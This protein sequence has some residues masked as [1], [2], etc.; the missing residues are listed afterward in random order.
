MELAY[1]SITHVMDILAKRLKGLTSVE[2]IGR[3]QLFSSVVYNIHT[4]LMKRFQSKCYFLAICFPLS[5]PLQVWFCLIWYSLKK[6]KK[7]NIYIDCLLELRIDAGVLEFCRSYSQSNVECVLT[8]LANLCSL[9]IPGGISELVFYGILDPNY[10][11]SDPKDLCFCS[12]EVVSCLNLALK[13]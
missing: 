13:G 4:V 2:W 11:Q 3:G 10:S 9:P 5:N 6:K 1:G 12:W 8:F 7:K